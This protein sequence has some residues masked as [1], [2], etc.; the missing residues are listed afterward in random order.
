MTSGNDR[1][2]FVII[3]LMKN[4]TQ[5]VVRSLVVLAFVGFLA[6]AISGNLDIDSGTA[7]AQVWMGDDETNIFSITQ[8][9]DGDVQDPIISKDGSRVVFSM[10]RFNEELGFS[11]RFFYL[12]D[13]LTG[14]TVQ[15]SDDEY[16]HTSTTIAAD[17]SDDGNTVIY[18]MAVAPSETHI[19]LYD[20]ESGTTTI[21]VENTFRSQPK[22]S[23][24]GTKIVFFGI[25]S[26]FEE[27]DETVFVYDVETDEIE[28]V[29]FN[30][31]GYEEYE[32]V[33]F[34]ENQRGLNISGDGNVVVFAGS[35]NTPDAPSNTQISAVV[36]H[37]T[38]TGVT[39]LLT[40]DVDGGMDDGSYW[41]SYPRITSDGRYVLFNARSEN[42]VE[43][44][45]V[46]NAINL[47][48]YDRELDTVTLVNTLEPGSYMI[49]PVLANDIS[50]NGQYVLFT[51]YAPFYSGDTGPYQ[52]I[53]I[54]DM[55]TGEYY[56]VSINTNG[57]YGNHWSE[58]G[59]LSANGS[60]GVFASRASNLVAGD[61]ADDEPDAY[62]FYGPC[63]YDIN[64]DG[65][66]STGDL[67]I[68]LGAYGTSAE[69]ADFN[70]DGV[71]NSGDLVAFLAAFDAG[72]CAALEQQMSGVV[73]ESQMNGLQT[74]GSGTEYNYKISIEADGTAKT[75]SLLPD[76]VTVESVVSNTRGLKIYKDNSIGIPEGTEKGKAVNIY[77]KIQLPESLCKQEHGKDF[78]KLDLCK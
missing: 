64:S 20:V 51:T 11:Q 52:D 41:Y 60:V 15:I 55:A 42:L 34:G 63:P 47:Y 46:E 24:D 7:T 69:L 74:L 8:N 27:F 65:L 29:N 73:Y 54:K 36:A 26:A 19:F 38:D 25:T 23:G 14:E 5:T 66:I 21:A 43:D 58:A 77:A 12:Y 10:V 61:V 44:F 18:D 4:T 33:F 48:V 17:I 30:L 53:V 56:P 37:N 22:I 3:K 67:V 13:R 35:L 75:I 31:E 78:A 70:N 50:E 40:Q 39:E 45:I 62:L 6:T 16:A 49:L 59:S 71:V 9:I 76:F 57:E 72:S 32:P 68:L 2:F 28:P 1:R